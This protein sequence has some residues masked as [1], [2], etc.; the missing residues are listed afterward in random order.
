MEGTEKK[1]KEVQPTAR[2]CEKQNS[3]SAKIITNNPQRN[4]PDKISLM[5][6]H[7]NFRVE[8]VLH[9]ALE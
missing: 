5:P 2:K 8:N 4:R 6:N 1:R 3:E 9:F 7:S